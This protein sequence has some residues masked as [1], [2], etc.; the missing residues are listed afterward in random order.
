[1]LN[2]GAIALAALALLGCSQTD[3]TSSPKKVAVQ[4]QSKL[5]VKALADGTISVNGTGVD[6][7]QLAQQFLLLKE[8]GGI[9]WYYRESAE[10][11]P[12]PNAMRVMELV[13]KNKLPITFY[14]KP[15]FSDVVGPDGTP[16][17]R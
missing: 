17:P 9:V 13:V 2:L 10:A 6:L 5:E 1:M 14:T 4:K 15:D 8:A 7:H 16:R 11:E 12:H 3:S